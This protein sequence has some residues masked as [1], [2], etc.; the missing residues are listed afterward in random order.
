MARVLAEARDRERYVSY[1]QDMYKS[2]K[3]G[4]KS[5]GLNAETAKPF[6]PERWERRSWK[7]TTGKGRGGRKRGFPLQSLG[8]NDNIVS[9]I[10][11]FNL[12]TTPDCLFVVLVAAIQIY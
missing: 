12:C 6:G 11:S 1:L 9:Q 4:P 10:I 8:H 5:E 7:T 2:R 3:S